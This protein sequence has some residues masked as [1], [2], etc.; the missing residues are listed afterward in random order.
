VLNGAAGLPA[1]L[2]ALTEVGFSASDLAAIAHQNWRRVLS[3][4]WSQ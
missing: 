3:D 2:D 1:L 4:W